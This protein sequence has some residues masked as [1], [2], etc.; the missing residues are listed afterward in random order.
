VPSQAIHR[1]RVNQM[2]GIMNRVMPILLAVG[3]WLVGNVLMT[4]KP[5]KGQEAPGVSSCTNY[6][7]IDSNSNCSL[8]ANGVCSGSWSQTAH[9]ESA[10]RGTDG[11][12][13]HPCMAGQGPTEQTITTGTCQFRHVVTPSGIAIDQC[14]HG[15]ITD[16]EFVD[17]PSVPQCS[18]SN[19][20]PNTV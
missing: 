1:K 11:D 7:V 15:P 17:L 3:L 6:T 5:V 9:G 10:C 18:T 13:Q 2:Q 14:V 16:V 20:P 19:P 4:T 12:P 8:P